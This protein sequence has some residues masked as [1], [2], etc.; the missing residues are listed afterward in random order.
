MKKKLV[1]SRECQDLKYPKLVQGMSGTLRPKTS[2][3]QGASKKTGSDQGVF[4]QIKLCK[5]GPVQGM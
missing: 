1:L 3:V 4:G 2:H 5:S